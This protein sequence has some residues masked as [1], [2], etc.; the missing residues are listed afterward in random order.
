M[1]KSMKNYIALLLVVTMALTSFSCAN[2][3]DTSLASNNKT[4]DTINTSETTINA[5]ES[6]N[7]TNET[8]E[9]STNDT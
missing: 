9:S 3:T 2:T 6:T 1:V 5:N 7:K 8:T 4:Q